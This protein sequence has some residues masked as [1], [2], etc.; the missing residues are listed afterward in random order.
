MFQRM[1][2]TVTL[3]LISVL[4]DVAIVLLRRRKTA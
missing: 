4:Y 2:D 1:A 3:R